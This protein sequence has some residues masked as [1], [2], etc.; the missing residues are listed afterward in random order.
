MEDVKLKEVGNDLFK[1]LAFEQAKKCYTK[2][3][4]VNKAAAASDKDTDAGSRQ[5]VYFSN[6]SGCFFELGMY[7]EATTD[8]QDC[9][10][11]LDRIE[12]KERTKHFAARIFGEKHEPSSTTACSRSA[13]M[14]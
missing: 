4:Q 10:D 14:P 3:I 8:A 1:A 13:A 2:A 9:L 7:S 12:S 11:I 5:A 6:R